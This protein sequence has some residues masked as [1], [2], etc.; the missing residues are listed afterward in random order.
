MDINKEADGIVRVL[1]ERKAFQRKKLEKKKW[2]PRESG[3]ENRI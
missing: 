1:A 3:V 2:K